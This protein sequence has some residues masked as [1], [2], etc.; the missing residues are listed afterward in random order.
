MAP[1]NGFIRL[2]DLKKRVGLCKASIYQ[3]I[4]QDLF[5]R[6]VKLTPSGRAVGWKTEDIDKWIQSREEAK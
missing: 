3:L 1:N 5:P 4:A 6:Q 2:K